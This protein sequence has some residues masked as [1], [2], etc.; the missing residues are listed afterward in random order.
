MK[1]PIDGSEL[2]RTTA[3]GVPAALCGKCRGLWIERDDFAR[4]EDEAFDL[5]DRQKG[6]MVFESE[7]TEHPCPEGG[8]MLRR[9]QYRMYD[10]ELELCPAGH[11]YWLTAGED[12][13]VLELMQLEEK[14]LE[15]SE[16]AEDR[17]KRLL[18]QLRSGSFLERMRILFR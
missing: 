16:K 9:F 7:A 10:L 3:H 5:G 17:W 4:L 14:D 11:G 2:E 13:R 18:G 12:D 15:R 1:C 6:T 8:E